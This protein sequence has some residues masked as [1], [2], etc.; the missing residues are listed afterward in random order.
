MPKSASV[1]REAPLMPS[2]GRAVRTQLKQTLMAAASIMAITGSAVLPSPCKMPVLIW[3][4]PKRKMPKLMV[5][6]APA[7]PGAL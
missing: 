3:C 5:R 2:S 6:I 1:A 4:S 7:A